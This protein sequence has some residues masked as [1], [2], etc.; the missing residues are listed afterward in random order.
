MAPAAVTNHLLAVVREALS[1]IVRHA[2]ARAVD[3]VVSLD[4]DRPRCSP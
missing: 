2:Q 1:N 4:G 3:L